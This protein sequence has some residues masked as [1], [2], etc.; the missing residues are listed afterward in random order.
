MLDGGMNE[1]G[2]AGSCGVGAG[3]DG[4]V[5]MVVVEVEVGGGTRRMA[6]LDV[7]CFKNLRALALLCT[8]QSTDGVIAAMD[9]SK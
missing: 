5:G 3:G 9:H 8:A 2:D 4:E 1:L 7:G 6:E